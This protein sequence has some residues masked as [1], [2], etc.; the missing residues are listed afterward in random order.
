MG[1]VVQYASEKPDAP[2]ELR[3]YP[4]GDASFTLYE[5]EDDNYDYEKG[6]HSTIRFDWSDAARQLKIG[7]RQGKRLFDGANHRRGPQPR[8]SHHHDSRCQRQESAVAVTAGPAQVRH[9]VEPCGRQVTEWLDESIGVA[10]GE[11][12]ERGASLLEG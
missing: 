7:A 12:V 9:A 10:V 4:G 5:D 8:G 6:V 2:L 1:P 3:V 11:Q